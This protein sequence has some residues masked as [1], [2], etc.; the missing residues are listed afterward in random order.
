MRRNGDL[1]LKRAEKAQEQIRR[2]KLSAASF[3]DERFL[4]MT[5]MTFKEKSFL[6]MIEY[7]KHELMRVLKSR[8]QHNA[9]MNLPKSV[10]KTLK[11]NGIIIKKWRDNEI[12][13]RVQDYLTIE[14]HEGEF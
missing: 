9:I 13:E 8:N 12:D 10:R 5:G 1:G 11:R 7:N 2:N 14:N 3:N 6:N 4:N